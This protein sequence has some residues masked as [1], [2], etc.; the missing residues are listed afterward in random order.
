MPRRPAEPLI[1]AIFRHGEPPVSS[2]LPD[3]DAR[4]SMAHRRTLRKLEQPI[5]MHFPDETPLDEVLKHIK[6]STEEPGYPGISIY[7]N[8]EGLQQAGRTLSSTVSLDFEVIP[9]KDA[10]RLCLKQLGM[11][12]G[13]RDNFVMISSEDDA[14]VPSVPVHDDPILIVG[15]CLLALIA[16]GLG[17]LAAPLVSDLRRRPAAA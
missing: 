7:V 10:L 14:E 8:P 11:T 2:E 3:S 12:F 15:N 5:P 13:V 9:V 16:A 17:A 4:I 1:D 6:K